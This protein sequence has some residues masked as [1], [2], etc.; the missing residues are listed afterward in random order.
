MPVDDGREG[1]DG[2]DGIQLPVAI[3]RRALPRA[4][5]T[6]EKREIQEE[7]KKAQKRESPKN[8]KSE[9]MVTFSY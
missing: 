3:L 1:G 9:K 7:I 2:R 8:R 4:L 6:K 5:T